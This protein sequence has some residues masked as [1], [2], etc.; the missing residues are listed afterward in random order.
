MK[1]AYLNSGARRSQSRTGCVQHSLSHAVPLLQL[2]LLENII[3]C[4]LDSRGGTR[5]LVQDL[6]RREVV[7][8]IVVTI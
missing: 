1:H 3:F 2:V 7:R 5:L 8:T 4:Y 6:V